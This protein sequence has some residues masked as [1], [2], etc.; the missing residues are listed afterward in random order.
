MLLIT[1]SNL[2]AR[3]IQNLLALTK[4]ANYS[5]RRNATDQEH[6]VKAARYSKGKCLKHRESLA[7]PATV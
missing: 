6:L 5:K 3:K 1:D 4:I 7:A 2:S